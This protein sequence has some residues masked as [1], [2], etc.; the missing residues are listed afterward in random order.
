MWVVKLGGS[1]DDNPV[2]Q[3]WLD[4][5]AHYGKG[6]TVIV[7]GGGMFAD[8]VRNAQRRWHFGD[9]AAH[10]MAILAMQQMALMFHALNAELF[11]ADGAA[12]IEAA[13]R[14]GKVALW[15]PDYRYVDSIGIERSWRVTSDSLADG[16]SCALSA[17]RG[18]AGI[19]EL[20]EKFRIINR[21]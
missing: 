11:L 19:Y 7:P 14:Q 10:H 5:L 20:L 1:L 21:K 18:F 6:R 9:V 15:L 16:L 3:D 2:L 4:A 13:L 12:E 17:P 8:A